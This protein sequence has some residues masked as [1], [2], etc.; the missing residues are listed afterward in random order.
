MTL[1]DLDKE[2]NNV[3]TSDDKFPLYAIILIVVGGLV[4]V[5]I[6]A[7]LWAWW[8]KARGG[9]DQDDDMPKDI[10]SNLRTDIND[11]EDTHA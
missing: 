10:K 5:A 9:K 8:A 1:S 3:D 4:L 7:G 2:C 6:I 11:T